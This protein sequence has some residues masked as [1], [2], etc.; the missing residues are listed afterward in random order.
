MERIDLVSDA[1]LTA[2]FPE[3]FAAAI[4]VT[5]ASGETFESICE[6]PL[7]HSKNPLSDGEVEAKFKR[8]AGGRLGDGEIARAIDG[9]WR[10][11]QCED[12]GAFMA[13]FAV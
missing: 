10:L 13:L 2:L 5:M 4:K 11:D 1:K 12:L 8:L 9:V 3:T 7:G 6:Y